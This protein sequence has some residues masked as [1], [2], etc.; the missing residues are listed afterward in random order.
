MRMPMHGGWRR[1]AVCGALAL[2]ALLG[3]CARV[4]AWLAPEEAPVQAVRTAG[5]AELR[6]TDAALRAERALT[7]LQRIRAAQTPAPGAALPRI[8]EPELLERI[9]LEW[10]GPLATVVKDLA[11][12]AGYGFVEAGPRPVVPAVVSISVDG[13]ALIFVLRDVALQAGSGVLVTVDAARREVRIDWRHGWE[14][15]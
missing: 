5:P 12:K 14:A 15:S 6:L 11:G 7:G 13:E 3:G 10:I 1:A 4:E 2:A 8:V 9:S